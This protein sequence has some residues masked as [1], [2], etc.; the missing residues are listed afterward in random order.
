MFKTADPFLF[1]QRT[2]E[3][4]G[5]KGKADLR[6]RYFQHDNTQDN[7]TQQGKLSRSTYRFYDSQHDESQQNDTQFNGAQNND[8]QHYNGQTYDSIISSV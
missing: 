6:R 3:Q 4:P 2:F 7:D 5:N 1:I 8:P